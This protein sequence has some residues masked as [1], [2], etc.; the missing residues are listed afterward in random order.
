[1][2]AWEADSLVKHQNPIFFIDEIGKNEAEEWTYEE[3]RDL[4][5]LVHGYLGESTDMCVIENELEWIFLDAWIVKSNSNEDN[6]HGD[7][8]EMGW[9]LA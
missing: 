5:I 6:T 8:F 3:G 7:I 4:I 2:M 1:M 9:K